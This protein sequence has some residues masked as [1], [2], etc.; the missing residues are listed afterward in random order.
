MKDNKQNNEFKYTLLKNFLIDKLHE[1]YPNNVRIKTKELIDRI[2]EDYSI[3]LIDKTDLPPKT[4]FIKMELRF[5]KE[6]GLKS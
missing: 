4:T 3:Y 2:Y 6:Q 1:Y 5:S